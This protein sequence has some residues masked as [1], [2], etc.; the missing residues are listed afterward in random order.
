MGRTKVT[1]SRVKED[2]G[3]LKRMRKK[4]SIDFVQWTND[5]LSHMAFVPP[6]KPHGHWATLHDVSGKTLASL[7]EAVLDR[8]IARLEF[9]IDFVAKH[10]K[11]EA[12]QVSELIRVYDLM[13]RRLAPWNARS[14]CRTS[15]PHGAVRRRRTARYSP[16][17]RS[18]RS[19]VR[20]R[21][22]RLV[23]ASVWHREPG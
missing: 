9:S 19:G 12:E 10:A 8:P 22:C 21:P 2:L 17:R 18:R 6:R 20:D 23:S 7:P 11:T 4:S 14:D 1:D 16:S 13:H 5:P 3:V 15:R